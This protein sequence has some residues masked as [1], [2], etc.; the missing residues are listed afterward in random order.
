MRKTIVFSSLFLSALAFS[1][2]G[3]N[4]SNPQGAFN[5]DGAKDNPATGTPS[6]A[7]QANDFVVTTSGNTGIGTTSPTTKLHVNSATQGALRITD[8]TEADG[9]VLTSD[10]NGLGTWK[11]VAFSSSIEGTWLIGNRPNPVTVTAA[12]SV[13]AGFYNSIARL[14]LPSAGT[15]LV[16][17]N[18]D[19]GFINSNGSAPPAPGSLQYLVTKG[20]VTN[21][22]NLS[23]AI[24]GIPGTW[25]TLYNSMAVTMGTFTINNTFFVTT[26]GAQE[27]YLTVNPSL[28]GNSNTGVYLQRWGNTAESPAFAGLPGGLAIDRF[29][30]Y[31]F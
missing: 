6:A 18:A 17:L 16:F 23:G 1:Q 29:V 9:R 2:V 20:P 15:Y 12:N 4:T 11:P 3:I 8:G 21:A 27:L 13:A 22:T 14:S 10:A 24:G 28:S 19:F 31:K 26:T 30:A 5:V 7:Q 25:N